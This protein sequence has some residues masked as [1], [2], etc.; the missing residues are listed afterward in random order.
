MSVDKLVDRTYVLSLMHDA[1]KHIL[2][3]Y[4]LFNSSRKRHS[5]A[6]DARWMRCSNG[7]NESLRIISFCFP[8]VMRIFI[9]RTAD[10]LCPG[11]AFSPA[12]NVR[13]L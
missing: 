8:K 13:Y 5:A 10:M 7:M 3:E 11:P 2:L 6:A 12:I 1:K 4:V 9:M